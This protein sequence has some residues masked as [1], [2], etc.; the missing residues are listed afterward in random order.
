MRLFSAMPAGMNMTV[1]LEMNVP[2]VDITTMNSTKKNSG[3]EKMRCKSGLKGWQ[4][5]LRNQY[6]SKEEFIAYC[7]IYSNHLRLG[8]KSPDSAWKANPII[9]GSV[10]PSDYRKV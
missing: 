7:S 3:G 9:Q 5:R 10:V 6:A 4:G 8:Y 2:T 1:I